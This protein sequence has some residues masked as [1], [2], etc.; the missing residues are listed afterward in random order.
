M[1]DGMDTRAVVGV[2]VGALVAIVVFGALLLTMTDTFNNIANDPTNFTAES[3]ALAGIGP[4]FLVLGIIAI[5][6]GLA[7]WLFT[8]FV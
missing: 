8:R 4:L 2:V 3:R 5:P 1:T 7:L 6:I